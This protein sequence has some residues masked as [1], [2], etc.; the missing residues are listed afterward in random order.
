[1]RNRSA[2]LHFCR[3]LIHKPKCLEKQTIFMLLQH[4]LMTASRRKRRKN[5]QLDI[6]GRIFWTSEWSQALCS[7]SNHSHGGLWQMNLVNLD[8]AV[9]EAAILSVLSTFLPN[10]TAVTVAE[11][12]EKVFPADVWSLTTSKAQIAA[13]QRLNCSEQGIQTY[14]LLPSFP[15]HP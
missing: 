12:N 14:L 1:M 6:Q 5:N 9:V 7:I 15:K 11:K 13:V 4:I 3:L 2:W 8:R 10:T